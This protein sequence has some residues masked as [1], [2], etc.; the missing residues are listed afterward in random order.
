MGH[1]KDRQGQEERLLDVGKDHGAVWG[2][3]DSADRSLYMCEST[4]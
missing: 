2:D 4:S 1:D 3:D